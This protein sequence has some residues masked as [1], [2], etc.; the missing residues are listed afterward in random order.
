MRMGSMKQDGVT[1]VIADD[2]PVFLKG[3]QEILEHE[4]DFHL[5]GICEDGEEALKRI[6]DLRPDVALLDIS[7]PGLTGLDVA[8]VVQRDDL[9]T[10]I[11]LLTISD[12]AEVFNR[13]IEYGVAGY[14]LKE[15]AVEDL[16]SGIRAVLRGKYFF[17]PSLVVR[18]VA[19]GSHPELPLTIS[20]GL[21][22]L[23]VT[24]RKI[25][26][27]ISENRSSADIA[28]LLDIS[29]RTVEKHRANISE[30][31]QLHGAYS[32]VRFALQYR[33]LL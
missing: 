20:A 10:K 22:T 6:R 24:E 21:E 14:I 8:A 19:P 27:F 31:L 2:H 1:I 26:R 11:I 9:P 30:K 29:P 32:L 3:L 7:M 17:S 25:I 5:A 28:Q 18:K 12:Q 15:T 13:A 4:H 33:D 16:V 23:T